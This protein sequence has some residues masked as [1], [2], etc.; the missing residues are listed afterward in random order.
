MKRI[1]VELPFAIVLNLCSRAFQS[2]P[3]PFTPATADDHTFI[4]PL[5]D[6]RSLAYGVL[7]SV[8]PYFRSMFL[9][10]L[11][12][13]ALLTSTFVARAQLIAWAA[14]PPAWQ[15]PP[16]TEMKR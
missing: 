3:I 6:E 1:H 4:T 7:A 15:S 11:L 2:N 16:L 12:A 14:A 5:T 13:L 10:P 8:P 9:R